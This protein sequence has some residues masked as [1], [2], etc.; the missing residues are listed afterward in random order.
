MGQ[1]INQLQQDDD[2]E[3][4]FQKDE[5]DE[6]EADVPAAGIEINPPQVEEPWLNNRAEIPAGEMEINPAQQAEDPIAEEMRSFWD[7]EEAE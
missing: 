7:N 1:V 5:A 6:K 3:D 2:E 4:N